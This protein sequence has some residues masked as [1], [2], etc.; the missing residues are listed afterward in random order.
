MGKLSKQIFMFAVFFI[1]ID[2]ACWISFDAFHRA[3]S[4]QILDNWTNMEMIIVKEAARSSSAWLHEKVV[5]EKKDQQQV[6]KEIFRNYIKPIKLLKNGD[7]FI[8][9]R[10]HIIFDESDDLP[11]EY[12]GRSIRDI[13]RMQTQNGAEHYEYLVSGVEEG[14]EGKDWYIWLP[15]KG[16]EYAAWTSI[17]IGEET[18]TIGLSTPENEILE[19]AGFFEAKKVEYMGLMMVTGLLVILFLMIGYSKLNDHQQNIFQKSM[20]R[21]Q[22]ELIQEIEAKSSELNQK[23]IQLL[24]A[25]RAKDEFLANMSHELRTPLNAVIGLSE[26]L[27]ENHPQNLIQE[28]KQKLQY[29]YESGRHLLSLIN[30]ILDLTK[31]ESG[32]IYLEKSKISIRSICASTMHLIEPLA[33]KKELEL[34]L[35]IHPEINFCWGDELR[36]KQILLNL[37]GNAV[38]FTPE[39]K[40][41]GLIVTKEKTQDCIQFEIWDTGIGIES[42]K[43]KYIFQPFI[44][45]DSKLSRLYGGS[46]LGLTLAFRLIQLHNGSIAVSSN[47]AGGCRFIVKIPA[48]QPVTEVFFHQPCEWKGVIYTENESFLEQLQELTKDPHAPE[49]IFLKQPFD[50]DQSILIEEVDFILLDCPLINEDSVKLADEIRN[51]MKKPKTPVLF[52]LSLDVPENT[53]MLSDVPNSFLFLHPFP[54]PFLL[55]SISTILKNNKEKL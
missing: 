51:L 47:E 23:N 17:K 25:S 28:Q 42:D 31:T 5:I 45:L 50:P 33:N 35:N 8:Y 10:H 3:R 15:E 24:K 18:W 9:N 38:K 27:R 55:K 11:E 46:G 41:I 14:T 34:S 52:T 26:T 44:Q 13:F 43:V 54:L 49:L 7:A 20:I 1:V 53:I 16:K 37:L 2:L 29:I 6:E 30:D 39:K 36:L 32:K 22:A 40:S 4:K 12:I 19:N 21:Y 48:T